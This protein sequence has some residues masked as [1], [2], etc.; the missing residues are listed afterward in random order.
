MSPVVSLLLPVER[1]N[2]CGASKIPKSSSCLHGEATRNAAAAAA[3][4]ASAAAASDQRC[5]MRRNMCYLR[6]L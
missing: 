5:V 6:F 2:V 3:A 1:N 4:A